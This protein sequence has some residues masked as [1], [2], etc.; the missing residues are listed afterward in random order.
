MRNN[1]ILMILAGMAA[2]IVLALLLPGASAIGLLGT[3]FVGALKAMAPLLVFLLVCSSVA[4]I[5][6][7]VKSRFATVIALYAIS[8]ILAAVVAVCG[9]RIWP[10]TM[11]LAE[12]AQSSGPQSLTDVFGTLLSSIVANPVD[13]LANGNYIGILFWA[14]L[15]GIALKLCK[16][17]KALE[18]ISELSDAISLIIKWV[19]KFAPLGILGLVYNS[20]AGNGLAIFEEY[21]RLV[22][23]LVGCM[24]TV[25]LVVNPL[26]A[27]LFTRTNP[28][29]LLWQCLKE[30][31]VSAF[32]TR[33]SAANIPFNITLCHK[34]GV[35]ESFYSVSIPLG[36]TINMNGAA[37]TIT[38]MTLCVCNTV[39]I[40]VGIGQALVLCVVAALAACGSSGV[41]GG[42]LLLIPMA[43]SLFNIGSDIASQAVAVG[44]IIGVVQDSFETALNSS[45]DVFF[46]AIADRRRGASPRK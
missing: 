23:L 41:A 24:L 40:E 3:V 10:V 25:A 39:G 1:F 42:S 16:G 34:L 38:V 30:S 43:C 20:V 21:G 36:S 33:S 6:S 17:G 32:F 9:S 5:Q 2:G 45:A 8:T 7:G 13:S 27:F 15:T 29:P 46:T 12:G 4:N 28:Y 44:F 11:T 19:I 26:I 37:V 35:D 22:L 31:G 18:V 14:I